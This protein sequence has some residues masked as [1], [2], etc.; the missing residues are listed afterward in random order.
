MKTKL[1]T[2]RRHPALAIV[3]ALVCQG[4]VLFHKHSAYRPIHQYATAG[5]VAHVSDELSKNPSDLN[6]PDDAGL[7]PLH[8]AALHCHTNVVTLLLDKGAK[9]NPKGADGATP[10]HLAAQ[11]GCA[12]AVEELLAKGA[13]VNARDDQDRTPLKRAEQWHQSAIAEIL[14]QHGGTE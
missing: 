3:L 13:K 6:L 11:E 2:I 10:L 8:L 4:C 7:T 9:V 14:R 5:D 1:W 12:N